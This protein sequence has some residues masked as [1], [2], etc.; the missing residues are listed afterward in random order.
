LA[1]SNEIKGLAAKTADF[2][3]LEA[4]RREF[5]ASPNRA[6]QSARAFST[7]FDFKLP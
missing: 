6:R 5:S 1:V 3:F 7:G 4:P 2:G